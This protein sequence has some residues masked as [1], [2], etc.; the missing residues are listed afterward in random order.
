MKYST[1]V[2]SQKDKVNIETGHVRETEHRETGPG[3]GTYNRITFPPL[4]GFP[5]Y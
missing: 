1:N 5:L 3:R 4:Q 2:N